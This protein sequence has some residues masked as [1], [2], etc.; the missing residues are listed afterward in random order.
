[1]QPAD[2]VSQ[3]LN[4]QTRPLSNS[5]QA[6]TRVYNQPTTQLPNGTIVGTLYKNPIDCLWKTMTT[7]GPLALYKGNDRSSS[8]R[9]ES[10]NLYYRFDCSLPANCTSYVSFPYYV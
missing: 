3:N 2:T 7:E 4:S 10:I 1:M 8:G 9:Q 5:Q 6:L